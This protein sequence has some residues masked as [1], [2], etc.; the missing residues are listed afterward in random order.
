M[1]NYEESNA[2]PEDKF[3]YAENARFAG[4]V[5]ASKKGYHT[6]GNL[7]V[8]GTKFQG[9]YQIPYWNGTTTVNS[10]IGFYNKS[11]YKYNETT[12]VWDIIPTVWPNVDDVFTDGVIYNNNLYVVNPLTAAGQGGSGAIVKANISAGVVTSFTV[13]QGGS[14]YTGSSVVSIF[15]GGGTDATATLTLVGG[16][17][18]AVNVVTG[19]TGYTSSP[20]VIITDGGSD[21]IGKISNNGTFSVVHGSIGTPKGIM[22]ETWVERLFVAGDKKAPNAWIASKP[23][24][25]GNPLNVE[26]FDTTNGALTDLLGKDG[27]ITAMR[28]LNNDMYM[29]KRDSIYTNDKASFAGG[30]TQ[31]S[32]LSRTGGATNQKSTIVVEN[33][34]WFYDGI[35]NQVRSLG[36]ER[37]FGADPRTKALTEI[38]KRSMDLLDPVQDNPVMIYNKRVIKLRLKTKGSPTNNFNVIFDYN[39]GG[40]SVD[41]GQAVNVNTVYNGSVY[42]GE[43]GTGQAFKDDSGYSANGAAF[44]FLANT[45]FMD[46]GRPDTYKRSRYIYFKGKLS[47]DQDTTIRLYRD[48]DYNLYSE[49]YIPSPH[50]QGIPVGNVSNDGQ[51]RSA[52]QGNAVWGGNSIDQADDIPTY[53]IE[54]LISVNR[55]SNLYALG[56]FST[57]NGGKVVAEQLIIKVIDENENYKRSNL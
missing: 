11:F 12:Q 39:T 47:Y 2:V 36:T 51:W 55:I 4:K 19:G 9:M 38:I 32:L 1:E 54:E 23:G 35:N 13:V 31:F 24:N 25:A 48:G 30:K 52:E 33:D 56:L 57:I 20:T 45:P 50:A 46:D 22:M 18:T 15:G 49:Y 42:Y 14:G 40:F 16:V 37:N 27:V 29:F 17:V 28:V 5:C 7:L 3:Y 41:I 34:I 10:L 8:G 44:P 53:K 26:D 6:I 43:D 21:G